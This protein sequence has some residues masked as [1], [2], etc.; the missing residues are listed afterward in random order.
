MEADQI[1]TYSI[2]ARTTLSPAVT[3][4]S[5]LLQLSNPF[6]TPPTLI[7]VAPTSSSTAKETVFVLLFIS[8]GNRGG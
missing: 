2:D 6:S 3:A 4:L 5:S 1:R 7:P 8:G